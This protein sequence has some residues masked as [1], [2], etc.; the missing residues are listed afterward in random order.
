MGANPANTAGS[1]GRSCT[2]QAM[3]DTAFSLS[4]SWSVVPALA[5]AATAAVAAGGWAASRRA[6][7]ETRAELAAERT[8]ALTGLPTRRVWKS[9]ASRRLA[10]PNRTERWVGV[11]DLDGLKPV[12]DTL[13]H[14]AG[15]QL[16]AAA[17]I[18]LGQALPTPVLAGRLGG[19]E[20]G[21]LV[22]KP[23]AGWI[24]RLNE[25][26]SAEP[27]WVQG[28]PVPVRASVGAVRCPDDGGELGDLLACAD[29]RM[30][31]VKTRRDGGNTGAARSAPPRPRTPAGWRAGS[32]VSVSATTGDGA[33]ARCP[34]HCLSF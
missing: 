24:D 25:H 27:V 28:R 23:P 32:H 31:A 26:V 30:Y 12:N 20:F 33:S 1:R 18:R 14:D 9:I 19:D 5:G 3:A 13:G 10:T 2:V 8:D 22:E 34:G 15:D 4:R 7:A 6:L 29:A 16:L 11:L 21:L 17:A